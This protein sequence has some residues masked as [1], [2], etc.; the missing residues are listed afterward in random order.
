MINMALRQSILIS[1]CF[2][3]LLLTFCAGVLGMPIERSKK[4]ETIKL[5]SSQEP[6]SHYDLSLEQVKTIAKVINAMSR[7]I[8]LESTLDQEK[9]I[10]G[11]IEYTFPKDPRKSITSA[12]FRIPLF[13]HVGSFKRVNDKLPW[14]ESGLL[15]ARE[16]DPYVMGLSW[17]FF[18]KELGLVF[19]KAVFEKREHMPIPEYHVFYFHKNVG[20]MYLQ[21]IFDTRPDASNLKDGYPKAF[22]EVH[23]YGS[24]VK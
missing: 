16:E 3:C 6:G 9:D 8:A 1:A 13:K 14:H 7:V 17:Y 21:Y 18:T 12:Y 20:N 19:D 5:Y 22:H 15:I 2:L 4:V 23:I 11:K 24:V 10:L